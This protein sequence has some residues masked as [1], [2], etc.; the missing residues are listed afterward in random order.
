[1][2]MIV[3]ARSLYHSLIDLELEERRETQ[4]KVYAFP[5]LSLN[6][7]TLNRWKN[8]QVL[9]EQQPLA[10]K[11]IIIWH[12]LLSN[13]ISFHRTNKFTLCPLDELLAY[14]QSKRKK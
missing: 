7:N 11:Q 10:I 4:Q 8:L 9:L 13:S 2:A 14:L 5:G 1:M 3:A 6:P 12:D